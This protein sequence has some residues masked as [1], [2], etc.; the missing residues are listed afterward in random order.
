MRVCFT[1]DTEFS[2]A[3]AFA[4]P[5]LRP[6]G[7]PMVL[8][9]AGGRSQGLEFLL[10]CFRRHGMQATFFVETV[11]RHYFRDDPM[12]K[13]ATRIA[14]HGH[15]VQ[16]HVHPCWS[17]FQHEDWPQRVRLQPRQDDLPGARWRRRCAAAA[18]FVHV[19]GMGIAGA[20]GFPRG[21]LA[22]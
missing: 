9:E 19:C 1:I 5:A 3:G 18:R 7:V 2:I 12:R 15:E 21:E 4:D 10:D 20:A 6:V 17:V 8:C 16:L 22:A 14:Q 11:Q 13:L